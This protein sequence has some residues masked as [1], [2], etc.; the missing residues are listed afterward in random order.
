MEVTATAM[1]TP[2]DV[3]E[4]CFCPRFVY[5]MHCL[6][7]AQNEQRRYKVMAGRE[8]H[9][10]RKIQNKDYLRKKIGCVD[11]KEDV[12]LA[13]ARL[14]V[15][16]RVDEI[17]TLSDGT[18]APLDYKF[19]EYKGTIYNT[20]K[21]Q[22]LLYSGLIKEIYKVRVTRGFI[23]FTRS[24]NK[25]IEVPVTGESLKEAWRIVEK[26]FSIIDGNLY[27]GKC[28]SKRQCFDCTYK[29]ICI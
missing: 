25:M 7:I 13:S 4:Y 11:K 10:K 2:V 1:I 29:N 20:L 18:M 21:I 26:V 12:Y 22:T 8:L 23:C 5:F 9:E 3:M 16:G 6:N 24:A 28:S 27:P 14:K 17:L 15:R 19:A